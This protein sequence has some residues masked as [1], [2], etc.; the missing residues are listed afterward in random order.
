ML[1]IWFTIAISMFPQLLWIWTGRIKTC[2]YY[3]LHCSLRVYGLPC[4]WSVGN[5]FLNNAWLC[6]ISVLKPSKINMKP[7]SLWSV[8]VLFCKSKRP[9]K[10]NPNAMFC[11]IMKH[12]CIETFQNEHETFIIMKRFCIVLPKQATGGTNVNCMTE[13]CQKQNMS[14]DALQIISW[15]NHHK[16]RTCQQVHTAYTYDDACTSNYAYDEARY[17]HTQVCTR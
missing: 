5:I 13:T 1:N 2:L 8:C 9:G 12:F 17:V 6:N 7:S 4:G 15:Q 10:P 16:K 3:I 14:T 11:L